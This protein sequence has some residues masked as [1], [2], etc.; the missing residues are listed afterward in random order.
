[1]KTIMIVPCIRTW[2]YKDDGYYECQA[3]GY[4][5]PSPFLQ[6]K[7][8]LS[9]QDYLMVTALIYTY[10]FLL[11]KVDEYGIF[12][13]DIWSKIYNIRKKTEY[14]NQ[15]KYCDINGECLFIPPDIDLTR[16]DKPNSTVYEPKLI[17]SSNIDSVKGV[18]SEIIATST[19]VLFVSH[20]CCG[21]HSFSHQ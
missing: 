18:I 10:C 7:D 9:E 8:I 11:T 15:Y 12:F 3:C 21:I 2:F 1:M 13:H 14:K 6:D 5:V 17:T 20:L 16:V 19:D 4:R